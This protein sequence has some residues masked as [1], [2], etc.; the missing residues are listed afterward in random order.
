AQTV[1]YALNQGVVQSGGEA[2]T[3][4]LDNNRKTFAKTGTNES[5]YM[6]TGGFVP[7][8]AAYVAVGN[9]ESVQSFNNKTINGVYHSTWYGMYIATPAWK[10]F[11]NTYLA[12][13]KIPA[14]NSYGTPDAAYTGTTATA[15]SS[16][17]Q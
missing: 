4:Q 7:Q 6:L 15:T 12:A 1:A 2:A 8:V 14:N 10:A 9:A 17:T 16:S 5:T 11:M 13:A 3:T